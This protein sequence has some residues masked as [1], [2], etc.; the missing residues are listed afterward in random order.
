VLLGRVNRWYRTLDTQV[1]HRNLK[2]RHAFYRQ[3]VQDEPL[4]L[5]GAALVGTGS[6]GYGEIHTS[7][8]SRSTR[9][10]VHYYTQPQGGGFSLQLDGKVLARL[11][12]RAAA[13]GPAYYSFQTTPGAHTIR[14]QLRGN[15][16][17][18]LFGVTAETD[19][20]GVV[21]DTLG[22]G[23]SR[24]ASQLRWSEQAWADAVRHRNPDLV[25]YAYGTNEMMDRNRMALYEREIR[26]VLARMRAAAPEASCLLIT[27]FDVPKASRPRLLA[28]IDVQ[29]RVARDVGCGF[30]NGYEF[31][32][33]AGGMR[34]W[35]R[36]RPPLASTDYIHL[37]ERGY[38]YAGIAMGD[39]LMRA[40]DLELLQG[41]G[42]SS[43]EPS[44]APSVD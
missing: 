1:F 36:A 35:V 43:T 14:A 10:E 29:R 24:M 18:R 25:T 4:G 12:T 5:F 33:G 44:A 32:G 3:D 27:P 31:M 28:I 38:V 21:V 39:A 40:Y 15:G 13:P 11:E 41:A 6:T 8:R 30:W 20:P 42:V 37:T 19:T 17:V 9:F 23:G 2:V 22:I 7:P 16:P 26:Q 34:R